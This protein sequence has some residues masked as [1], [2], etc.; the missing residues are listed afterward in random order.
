MSEGRHSSDHG[1]MQELVLFIFIMEVALK[2]LINRKVGRMCWNASTSNN[3]SALPKTEESFF[4]IQ[5]SP[6]FEECQPRSTRLQVCLYFKVSL[7]Q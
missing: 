6:C 2:E 3:L 1:R 5:Y 7:I 4:L